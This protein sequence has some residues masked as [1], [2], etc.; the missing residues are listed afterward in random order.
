M[1]RVL[2]VRLDP[3]QP[4]CKCSVA[5]CGQGPLCWTTRVQKLPIEGHLALCEPQKIV[6]IMMVNDSDIVDP[7]IMWTSGG[8]T[9]N[10]YIT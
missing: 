10:P 5:T 8:P 2:K 1:C 4:H 7:S 6:V 9:L 3:D